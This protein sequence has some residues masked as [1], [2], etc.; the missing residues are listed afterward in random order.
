MP[1]ELDDKD[2]AILKKLA[3]ECG[4]LTCSG[5]GHMFHSILPPIS[6]HFAEDTEDFLRRISRLDKEELTYL[7]DLIRN[8][9]E[10]LGCMPVEDVEALVHYIRDT[11]SPDVAQNVIS[12]YESG[13][14]CEH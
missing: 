1:R 3:P 6:N 4:D 10:S 7:T 14:S 13:G 11:I 9:E 12:V 2:I 8:G 5:S